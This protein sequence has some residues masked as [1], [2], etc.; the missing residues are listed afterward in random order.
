M[1]SGGDAAM[2]TEVA[3]APSR[4]PAMFAL[5][6]VFIRFV[7]VAELKVDSLV[8][9]S[10][11]VTDSTIDLS[12]PL[13]PG[14]DPEFDGLLRGLGSVAKYCP[15][16]IIDCVMIWRKGKSERTSDDI[17]SNVAAIYRSR[18]LEHIIKE[19]K[20]L[21]SNFI[22]CR[23]LIEIIR[24]LTK[25]TL[26]NDLGIKLEEMVFAQLRNIDPELT[27]RSANRQAN[28]ELFSELI[29][30][31]SN[32]RFAT[33]SDRFV[34]EISELSRASSVRELKLEL[35]IR[36]MRFLKLKIYPMESLEETADFLGICSE[37]FDKSHSQRIK[38]AYAEVLAELLE[39]VASVAQAEVN[40]PAWMKSVE[41]IYVKAS[42]MAT[43]RS[44]LQ[45]AL[46]VVETLLC[47]SKKEFFLKNYPPVIESCLQNFKNKQLKTSA[48][49]SIG[50]LLLGIE[51]V[52]PHSSGAVSPMIGGPSQAFTFGTSFSGTTLGGT[53]IGFGD[54]LDDSTARAP[55]GMGGQ[56]A[57]TTSSIVIGDVSVNPERL[58]I[59][60]RSFLLLLA[61]MEEALQGKGGATGNTGN[62][63]LGVPQQGGLTAASVSTV[64]YVV[65]EGKVKIP[66][67]P[68]PGP[69]SPTQSSIESLAAMRKRV[70]PSEI[71]SFGSLSVVIE[72]G[73][74]KI[75]S[76]LS[77]RIVQRMSSSVRDHLERVNTVLGRLAIALDKACGT[78]LWR[79]VV[80]SSE[81]GGS[82]TYG[83][84]NSS[85]IPSSTNSGRRSSFSE[86]SATETRTDRPTGSSESILINSRDRLVLFDLLKNYIECLPRFT[87]AGLSATRIVEMMS[88]YTLHKDDNVRQAALECLI[89]ISEITQG[90]NDDVSGRIFWTLGDR[91]RPGTDLTQGVIR[92]LGNAIVA[93]VNDRIAS[94]TTMAECSEN[95]L[96]SGG[97]G[98]YV[99][100]IESWYE[101]LKSGEA[102]LKGMEEE[103]IERIVNEI[104]GKGVLFLLSTSICVRR[105][106]IRIIKLAAS[107]E[108]TLTGSTE[109]LDADM[110]STKSKGSETPEL[111]RRQAMYKASK[112][113]LN[114]RKQFMFKG[115]S[116]SRLKTQRSRIIHIM[117]QSGHDL[118][119]RH[120]LQ[121]TIAIGS[122]RYENQKHQQQHQQNLLRLLGMKDALVVIAGSENPQ[123]A[124]IWLRCV[125]DL[126]QWFHE[127]ASS[128]ALTVCLVDVFARLVNL[129][130]SIQT[131][132]DFPSSTKLNANNVRWLGASPGV[133]P[134][135]VPGAGYSITTPATDSIIDQWKVFLTFTAATI[136]VARSSSLSPEKSPL[137]RR[138]ISSSDTEDLPKERPMTPS[139]LFTMMLPLLS[140]ERN[141]IRQHVVASLGNVHWLSY[142]TLLEGLQP[143]MRNVTEDMRLRPM[144]T[145][146]SAGSA[147]PNAGGGKKSVSSPSQVA[148]ISNIK[149]LE[150]LRVEITHLI[151]LVADFVEID[152]YR[153]NESIVRP[154]VSYI[155]DTAKFLGSSDVKMEWDYQMLRYYFCNL[156]DRVYD[157]LYSAILDAQDGG[158]NASVKLIGLKS[159]ESVSKYFP[160]ELRLS[161]FQLIEQW[162]GHGKHAVVFLDR[163]TKTMLSAL[164]PIK[165]NRERGVLASTMDEQRK[166]LAIAALKTMSTLC[167]GSLKVEKEFHDPTLKSSDFSVDDI[168]NWLNDMFK[169]PDE[170]VHAIALSAIEALLANNPTMEHLMEHAICE[171]YL[172]APISPGSISYFT[173]IVN[174]YAGKGEESGPL[175]FGGAPR[176]YPCVAHRMLTLA[177]YKAGESNPQVRKGAA[178]L[179]RAVE[180]RLWG[181]ELFPDPDV[182]S[183]SVDKFEVDDDDAIYESLAIVSS[184]PAMYKSAQ[185]CASTRLASQRPELTC[186]VGANEVSNPEGI[187]DFLTFIVPW[188]RNLNLWQTLENKYDAPSARR[189]PAH[190][191]DDDTDTI[192]MEQ[193][194]E[195]I[196]DFLLAVGIRRRNPKFVA[197]AKKVVVYLSRTRACDK[198]STSRSF[199]TSS[200]FNWTTL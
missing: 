52:V 170:A 196:V 11:S 125:P 46:P 175:G 37:F 113:N 134:Q 103:E 180:L 28:V 76:A 185:K 139:Q 97:L 87:P 188:V 29:G 96:K 57:A 83:S 109:D 71:T 55:N 98:L 107:F 176:D 89:R 165:D 106:G 49:I 35:I 60:M 101:K 82:F 1:S 128:K 23:A 53:T 3:A 135:G 145:T 64:G 74:T 164:D 40:L 160:C 22:L 32:I 121:P 117:E 131:A 112:S 9:S 143:F 58:T 18:E 105:M 183:P 50:S 124:A 174:I 186:D 19:R 172:R 24:R 197:H 141:S 65:V 187:K 118:V 127:F 43:K 173:A 146:E 31:L 63:Q 80:P 41:S 181:D 38:H 123:E 200:S 168:T 171:C 120:F 33:V 61:D 136:E 130:P 142:K 155:R 68:F 75:N 191:L 192:R 21:V 12:V 56:A 36:S 110:H 14:V 4:T 94:L 81:P 138:S 167:K 116:T 163:E 184:L 77:D 132:S 162:C 193:H 79:D 59:A 54:S 137:M 158:R 122:M 198:L 178:R 2:P 111:R 150:R 17:P 72:A 182:L 151:S 70:I 179:L 34:S 48:L 39:P 73:K 100:M 67:P 45:V 195:I 169:S 26:P 126:V 30:A 157:R 84:S 152:S 95:V 194:V 114:L 119:S 93:T 161:L 25:E 66:H 92:I 5:Q 62:Q 42:R 20:S 99:Q 153:S 69:M 149:R 85:S 6:S 108:K 166:V 129:H 10:T 91:L 78:Y 44:H 90:E 154:I 15:K 133:A 102:T 88:R 144:R 13:R 8:F 27:M 148:M 189:N 140:S 159:L 104:E 47:V 177:L 16:L 156:V 51:P 115:V 147:L 199:S 190:T 86:L 7:K